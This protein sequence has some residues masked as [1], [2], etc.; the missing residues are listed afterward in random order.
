MRIK[1]RFEAINCKPEEML[2]EQISQVEKLLEKKGYICTERFS[3]GTYNLFY[4]K[5]GETVV[6]VTY[7][8]THNKVV[9]VLE[10]K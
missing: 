4:H 9:L 6:F 8:N 5:E 10:Y 1:E 2:F 3:Y 7:Y